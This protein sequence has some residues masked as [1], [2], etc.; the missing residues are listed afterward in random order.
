MVEMEKMEE[1]RQ[2]GKQERSG[3]ASRKLKDEPRRKKSRHQGNKS[4]TTN[5]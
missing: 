2:T 3:G 4:G 5:S 1:M